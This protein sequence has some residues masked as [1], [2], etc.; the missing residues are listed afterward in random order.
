MRYLYNIEYD[1]LLY[2][3]V[4]LG[5]NPETTLNLYINI[6]NMISHILDKQ[7]LEKTW[8]P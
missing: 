8:N 3:G 2:P 7:K 6:T 4:M 1:E 5:S